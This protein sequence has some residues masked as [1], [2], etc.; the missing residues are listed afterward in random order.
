MD[1]SMDNEDIK[2]EMRA[3]KIIRQ[4]GIFRYVAN[5]QRRNNARILWNQTFL[6]LIAVVMIR[7]MRVLTYCQNE[8][9]I[10]NGKNCN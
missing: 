7:S 3:L 5:K 6:I 1:S 10:F 2:T 9:K 8:V 4:S